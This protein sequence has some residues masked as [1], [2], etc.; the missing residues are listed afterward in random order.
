MSVKHRS[1]GPICQ[2]FRKHSK[3]SQQ[4]VAS[5]LGYQNA[6]MI[7]NFERGICGLPVEKVIRYAKICDIPESVI[8]GV[9]LAEHLSLF[10][11]ESFIQDEVS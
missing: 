7:S 2:V 10:I 8:I 1:L 6:Q 11:G 3:R 4:D 9:S 5:Q